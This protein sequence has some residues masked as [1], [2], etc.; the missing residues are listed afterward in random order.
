MKYARLLI[1]LLWYLAMSCATQTTP[2][3]GP[4][5]TIPPTVVRYFPKENQTNFKGKQIEIEFSE[6]IVLNNPKDEIIII[7]ATGKKTEFKLK[8]TSLIIVPELPLRDSTTYNINFREGVKDLTEGNVAKDR[9]GEQE[10]DLH[11]AFSTGAIIDTLVISGTVSNGI[12]EQ[13]PENITVA[14]YT[15]DTFDIFED[16]P[17]YF[18]KS[19]KDG[20][21]AITNLKAGNYKLYAFEDKNK[22]LKAETRSEKFGFMADTIRLDTM[23]KSLRVPMVNID[24]RRPKLTSSR[25]QSNVNIIRFNKSMIDYDFTSDHKFVSTFT[26]NQT[27]VTAYYPDID[28]DSLMVSIK[29]IDSTQQIVDTLIY[30]KRDDRDKIK[31][32]FNVSAS[33]PTYNLE[34]NVFEMSMSFSKPLKS[35]NPD[36]IYLQYD[37]TTRIPLTFKSLKIDTMFNR[38]S[39][40]ES[41]RIDSLP[42]SPKVTLAPGYLV[43]IDDDSSAVMTP[44]IKPVDGPTTA[45]LIVYVET[46]EPHFII[47]LLNASNKVVQ[48]A[49]DQ[50]K[51]TFKYLNPET[52]KVRAIIDRNANGVWDTAIYPQNREPEK[53]VYFLNTNK[54]PD[55]PL[56]AN[57]EVGPLIFKF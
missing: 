2:M 41:V 49:V 10:A 22:N 34:T 57:W 14:L 18:T 51:V 44:A 24:T 47:Q 17:D 39:I 35:I 52:L 30:I 27:E 50:K 6:A 36:S 12:N 37:S 1:F 21:F 28:V 53:I 56:R 32:R 46:A 55:T 42:M 9:S 25:N 19:S 7:P 38:L 48:Q 20:R 16:N 29:A 26:S 4:K 33:D 54:K 43:S 5:D 15:S 23:V 3:G 11:L 40:K 31:E 13:I 45:I 8:T